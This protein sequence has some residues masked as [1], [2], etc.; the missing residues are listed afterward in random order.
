MAL[1]LIPLCSVPVHSW[2]RQED[3]E[4]ESEREEQVENDVVAQQVSK[5]FLRPQW[6]PAGWLCPRCVVHGD[7]TPAVHAANPPPHVSK[8]CRKV[9]LCLCLPWCFLH[10]G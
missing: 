9:E 4:L 5:C 1:R 7:R 6:E 8:L 3:E 2:S 10:A